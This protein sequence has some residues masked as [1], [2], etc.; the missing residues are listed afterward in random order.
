MI[1]ISNYSTC[2][3]SFPTYDDTSHYDDL[4]ADDRVCSTAQI[5]FIDNKSVLYIWLKSVITT[6]QKCAV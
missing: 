6:A 4:R 2:T 1:T 3:G 5:P